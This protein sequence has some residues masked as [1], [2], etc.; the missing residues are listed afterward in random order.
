MT[1][2]PLDVAFLGQLPIQV[3][4][5]ATD[6]AEALQAI[7][8]PIGKSL[9]ALAQ[10]FGCDYVTARRKYDDFRKSGYN[11]RVLVNCSKAAISKAS[12]YSAS[13]ESAFN[14]GTK[15][16][17]FVA[18]AK[19][20][21]ESYQRN[22]AAAHRAFGK[23]WQAGREITG[24]DNSLPRHELPPGC[25]QDN[26][27]RIV[28]DAFALE[29]TRRGLGRAVAKYGPQVFTTRAGLWYG[30]HYAIDDVWHDN[31]VV[32][33]HGRSS[34]IVRVLQLG[35]MEIFSGGYIAWGCKPRVL[36]ADGKFDNLKEKYARLIVCKILFNE[37]YSPRGT[38]FIAEHGTAAISAFL[39]ECM[40]RYGGK[41]PDGRDAV[42]VRRSGITGKEQAVLGWRGQGGGN[43]RTKSWLESFHN[44]IHNELAAIPGQT[45]K[46]YESRPEYT[47]HLLNDCAEE[48][49]ALA[50]I[51]E[52][53]PQRAAQMQLRLL[54]YHSD[55]L[56]L[57][58][59]L[60]RELNQRTW[61][62]LEGWDSIPGN[63]VVEY[64]TA[65]SSAQWLTNGEFSALPVE[66]QNLIIQLAQA[67]KRY[68]QSRQLSPAEV[69]QRELRHAPLIKFPAFAIAEMLGPDFAR[70]LEVKGAYFRPFSDEELCPELLRYESVVTTS[71]GREEQLQDGHYLI[72][73]NPFDLA[74]VFVHD[75]QKRF[76]GTARRADR[77]DLD[78]PEQ[79][80]ASLGRTMHRTA[81]LKAPLLARHAQTMKAENARL[82]DLADRLD[83][84]RPFTPAEKAAADVVAELGADAAAD[85]LAPSASVPLDPTNAEAADDFLSA[86][87]ARE[88][89]E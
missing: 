29:A 10:R 11:I 36:R 49:K 3:R 41:L 50:I 71:E 2:T 33:G 23:A 66:S 77:A 1:L 84:T 6:W 54:H 21:A 69:R 55:F 82:N 17:R 8:K 30:S 60:Y 42:T 22:T 19:Q 37:G 65:P 39:E 70:E 32:F 52:K 89:R 83:E 20:L 48:L 67:D 18:Y 15:H 31:F 80:K 74:V 46:D 88:P 35:G 53:N 40:R 47:N 64:R 13:L 56:P 51:A 61:H 75:A 25:G 4:Q 45:G 34:Q 63:R 59:D 58:M 26:F 14:L 9:A 24:L 16:P 38:Q 85:I 73:I 62:Q 43:P 79:I 57:L 78:S 76:L 44:L 27:Y 86:I 81:Q 68:L 28:N 12:L 5:D 87:G 7:S 72:F